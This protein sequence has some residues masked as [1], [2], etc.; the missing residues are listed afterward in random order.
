MAWIRLA[1]MNIHFY[2][3]NI[4]RHLGEIVGP[5]VKIDHK[6]V[7]AQ[8]GKFARIAV[9][10]DLNKPLISQ[11]NFEG[12]IQR[13]EYEYLP[14]ICFVCGKIGHYKDACLDSAEVVLPEKI[15]SRS[16]IPTSSLNNGPNAMQ[17]MLAQTGNLSA[18]P[19]DVP[20]GE[21]HCREL[22]RAQS[23]HSANGKEAS[24]SDEDDSVV[25]ESAMD[26]GAE[27]VGLSQ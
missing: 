17:G 10:I 26:I 6:T 27:S 13:V 2:N 22:D 16:P 3:K 8:R 5:M 23:F 21:N 19:N 24:V 12:R 11:F 15:R 20:T 1:E 25:A 14:T 18:N 4:I 9:E 7:E